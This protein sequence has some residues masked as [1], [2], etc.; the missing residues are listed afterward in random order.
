MKVTFEIWGDKLERFKAL[1]VAMEK[2]SNN[3][4]KLDEVVMVSALEG[5]SKLE[6]LYLNTSDK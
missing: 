1:K 4:W 5:L 3:D 2:E 6:S